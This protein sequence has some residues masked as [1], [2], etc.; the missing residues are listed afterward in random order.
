MNNRL[1]YALELIAQGISVF[2]CNRDK[3]P[4]T[5]NGFKDATIDS[6]Q[7]SQWFSD[8]D[9]LIG[10]PTGRENNIFALDVDPDGFD[11]LQEVSEHLLCERIHNTKRGKHFLY[12][13]PTT[14]E[15]SLTTAG[16]VSQG[17]DSRGRGGYIIYWPAEGMACSGKL[18]ERIA[19][20]N[21]LVQELCSAD[22][23]HRFDPKVEGVLLLEGERNVGLTSL[24]GRL[25]RGGLD[26]GQIFKQLS[27][28]NLDSC[29]PSLGGDELF[30]IAKS[31]AGYQVGEPVTAKK[32]ARANA[33]LAWLDEFEMTRQE[34][35]QI[36]D[37][38][39]VIPNLVPEGHVVVV[40]APPG[41]GK[42]TL[43]FHLCKQLADKYEVV[44]VHGDTNPSDA[45]DYFLQA[46]TAGLRYLTPDMKIG[47][48]MEHVGERLQ[49]LALSDADLKGQVWV[50]D[51]FKKMTDM[52]QKSSLKHWLQV[53]RKLSN[54]GLSLILLTHTNKHLG[55]DGKTVF[56]GTGDLRADVDE[57]IYLD[58]IKA[59][60]GSLTVTTRPD[61]VRAIIEP[62]TFEIGLDR[63]VIV[64]EKVV[65]VA[66]VIANSHKV[67]IDQDVIDLIQDALGLGLS[68]QFEIIQYCNE[69]AGLGEHKVRSA[70]KEYSLSGENRKWASV[71]VPGKNLLIYRSI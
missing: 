54:R 69:V 36:S 31:V 63:S 27:A 4:A 46:Q 37:P 29:R 32:T 68:K 5:K 61:K 71:K 3:S 44:Y 20:P 10:V 7:V 35:D 1:D 18:D 8:G 41:A 57:L 21:W 16:R 33:S 43:I 52:I 45:K 24:A 60:D 53:M 42:T 38:S 23:P 19:P 66:S 9:F 65:D 58:P 51:T 13:F 70:L 11:W 15:R 62:L 64:R 30:R 22:V 14:A 56:E 25:R 47:K 40:A 49:E 48:S 6:D 12:T 26:E 59:A 39:W 2:P 55:D 50:I 17:V 34:I 28:F 67:S